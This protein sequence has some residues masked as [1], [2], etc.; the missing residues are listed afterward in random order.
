MSDELVWLDDTVIEKTM[1][2]MWQSANGGWHYEA[3]HA[4]DGLD[5]ALMMRVSTVKRGSVLG[6]HPELGQGHFSS[7]EIETTYVEMPAEVGPWEKM[8]S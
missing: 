5:Q 1:T 8:K 3:D 6:Y 7:G 4:R 2:Y